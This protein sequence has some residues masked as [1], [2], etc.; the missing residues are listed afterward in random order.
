MI[1]FGITVSYNINVGSWILYNSLYIRPMFVTF[2]ML[3]EHFVLWSTLKESSKLSKAQ[4]HI[5]MKT[6]WIK[7]NNVEKAGCQCWMCNYYVV[8]VNI[9]VIG[10]G[11]KIC[12]G[13][14]WYRPY[15]VHPWCD[16]VKTINEPCYTMM[17]NHWSYWALL[18][19]WVYGMG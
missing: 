15:K 10:E 2:V 19:T 13:A 4:V 17:A 6:T 8:R 1:I 18:K 14:W 11:C 5:V 9:W 12:V 7:V 3:H 16:L